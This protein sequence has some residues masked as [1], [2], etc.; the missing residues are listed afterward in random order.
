[1]RNCRVYCSPDFFSESLHAIHLYLQTTVNIC[2]MLRWVSVLAVITI[3]V[4]EEERPV[5]FLLIHFHIFVEPKPAKQN[6]KQQTR[7][8][9]M[10]RPL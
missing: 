2:D 10:L 5:I 7:T 9:V 8:Q 1:M 4:R 3:W 6:K